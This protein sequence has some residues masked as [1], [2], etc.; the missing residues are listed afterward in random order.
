MQMEKP[1]RDCII[2]IDPCCLDCSCW[3]SHVNQ[4]H[5]TY[6]NSIKCCHIWLSSG[7]DLRAMEPTESCRIWDWELSKLLLVDRPQRLVVFC[8]L[9][10]SSSLRHL[11]LRVLPDLIMARLGCIMFPVFPSLITGWIW[12]CFK[13]S[14]CQDAEKSS[15]PCCQVDAVSCT[16]YF[17]CLFLCSLSCRWCTAHAQRP[18]ADRTA[19]LASKI[20]SRA[21]TY[22]F[23]LKSQ[24]CAHRAIE[25]W[26]F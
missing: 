13:P 23:L 24:E 20:L 11:P 10:I 1:P 25:S 12:L 17:M 8:F 7:V 19:C 22:L 18:G 5:G 9:A 26:D 6:S 16:V 15:S 4:P 3:I 21:T 2:V 14:L